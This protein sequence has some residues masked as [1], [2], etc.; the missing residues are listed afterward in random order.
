ME[1]LNEKEY[2]EY[3]EK[4]KLEH[5]NKIKSGKCRHIFLECLPKLKNNNSKIINWQKSPKYVIFFIYD[6]IEGNIE[7]IEYNKNT[8]NLL[9]QYNSKKNK[10][11]THDLL[12]CY[13]EGIIGRRISNFKLEIGAHIRDIKRNLTI[14]DKEYR[15]TYNDNGNLRQNV[16]W[17]KY[18][19]NKCG[20][21]E[22]WVR[23]G[24]L[25]GEKTGC[26]CCCKNNKT[27]V[28][29]IN[30]IP[31]TAPWM[32]PYFQGGYEEAK[33]YTHSSNEKIFPI[34]PDCGRI[35]DKKMTI[36]KIYNRH[37]IGCSCCDKIPYPEKFVFSI[38]EQLDLDFQIQ[39]SK[40]TFI[41]CNK[42]KYDFYFKLNNELYVIETHGIQHYEDSSGVFTKSIKEEQENDRLKKELA[43]SN[44][45]KEENYIVIDCRYSTLE[46][47]R[48]N[49]NGMLN[50]RLN[51]LFDLSKVDWLKC[52]EF[53]C[54]NL[55]K[56]ACKLKRDTPNLTTTEIGE[57][58]KLEGQTIR[59]YLKQGSEIWNWINYNAKEEI[60]RNGKRCSLNSALN[61]IIMFKNQKYI[62]LFK[63]GRS[64]ERQSEKLFETKLWQANISAV[65]R[66][67]KPQ[68]KGYT[69]KYVQDLT[70]E[71][72]IKY[73]IENKL[74]ELEKS[75]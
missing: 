49:D 47:I 55:V 54:S 67:K 57:I 25:L 3:I 1:Q 30:D 73:D 51:E 20:W 35:K 17:Y 28:E 10:L 36:S 7:I 61:P 74:K 65:C 52:A 6:N 48:D 64:L 34:C 40:S 24:S 8:R 72:R 23:E 22:G 59:K 62:Y 5:E 41:W 27:L 18:T 42:Y 75:A 4:W 53:S 13:I 50:S 11:Y 21:T 12:N 68:Y 71:E 2:L 15:P 33:L 69:F 9:L 58:M 45:I 46:W 29:G 70:S 63:S 60:M 32:I 31:S 37:S 56:I 26:G 14:T 16:K 44:G 19:C 39:L 38:L 66:G 43:L